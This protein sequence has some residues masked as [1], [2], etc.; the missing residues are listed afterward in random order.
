MKSGVSEA[1]PGKSKTRMKKKATTLSTQPPC[2]RM[3]CNLKWRL[4]TWPASALRWC[5]GEFCFSITNQEAE[6]GRAPTCAVIHLARCPKSGQLS[7]S[8]NP[9]AFVLRVP[10]VR[11]RTYSRRKRSRRVTYFA[12]RPYD[13]PHST[14]HHRDQRYPILPA[15]VHTASSWPSQTS[16]RYR[17][18]DTI[19]V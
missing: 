10:K 2:R 13:F 11:R 6:L 17:C 18:I 1:Q 4:G 7:R 19:A 9:Q 14:H 3:P 15:G 12:W 5:G 8:P 16:Q